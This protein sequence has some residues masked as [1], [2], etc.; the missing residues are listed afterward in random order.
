MVQTTVTDIVRSTV[1][2]DN[3]LALLHQVVLEFGDC[4]AVFTFIFSSFHHRDN[5]FGSSL[6]LICIVFTVNPFLECFLVFGRTSIAGDSILHGSFDACTKF[7]V[8]QSHTQTELA[9]VFE[10]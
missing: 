9:E 2:T 3:P 10:Q 7:L 4:C 6:A 5:L 1:T 8:G